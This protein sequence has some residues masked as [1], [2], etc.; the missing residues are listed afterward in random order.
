M[1]SRSTLVFLIGSAVFRSAV[2]SEVELRHAGA[3]S[4][5]SVT[6]WTAIRD[7]G[8]VRQQLDYSC[9]AA[10]LATVLNHY[11]GE[12]TTEREIL[13]RQPEPRPATFATLAE[14]ASTFGYEARGYALSLDAL[15]Q[16]NL[17]VILYVEVNGNRHFSVLRRASANS[18]M[19]ADPSMGNRIYSIPDFLNVWAKRNRGENEGKVLVV[20]PKT[21]G[22]AGDPGFMRQAPVRFAGYDFRAGR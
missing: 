12:A 13:E 1:R 14:L 2:G 21:H 8:V 20:L 7:G 19:L 6:P 16:L 18:V 5:L 15:A 22:V 3:H 17:P 4:A 9:G 10:A 11:Y